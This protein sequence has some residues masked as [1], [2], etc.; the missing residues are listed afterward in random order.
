MSLLS[1]CYQL[2]EQI[3]K[4]KDDFCPH[5]VSIKQICTLKVLHC[6]FFTA[7]LT[8]RTLEG[9]SPIEHALYLI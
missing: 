7:I 2:M 1:L 8:S 6:I 4:N 5:M 3:N 9:V